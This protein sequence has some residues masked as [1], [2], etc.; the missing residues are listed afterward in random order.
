MILETMTLLQQHRP[1]GEL[2]HKHV[3]DFK[4][5]Q[6][7]VW[8]WETS[9]WLAV[10]WGCLSSKTKP[11][12]AG[13]HEKAKWSVTSPCYGQDVRGVMVLHHLT[14]TREVG[15][16]SCQNLSLCFLLAVCVEKK[17]EEL[18][19]QVSIDNKLSESLVKSM[20]EN[21][22]IGTY[23][24]VLQRVS[25]CLPPFTCT[26]TRTHA[27]LSFFV[28]VFVSICDIK[29]HPASVSRHFHQECIYRFIFQHAHHLH[30]S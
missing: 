17:K 24:F 13:R 14:L 6:G 22:N 8:P 29:M 10:V 9:T 23:F 20:P 4:C 16:A 26:L 21:I 2:R 12:R 18:G 30:S 11:S 19:L 27:H 3:W 5:H 1:A 28:P 25:S 15:W 7:R